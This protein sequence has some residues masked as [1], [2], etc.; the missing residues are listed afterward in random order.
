M[1]RRRALQLLGALAAVPALPALR[2]FSESELL[3]LGDRI[4]EGIEGHPYEPRTLTREQFR[5]VEI[6]AE[7]IIPR[8]HTPGATDARVA[9]FIDTMLTDWHPPAERERFIAGLNELDRRATGG[10]FSRATS[11]HR[12]ALL[13]ALDDEVTSLRRS[14]AQG[15]NE[16]WFSTL[17]FLTVWGYYTSRAGIT[18]ELRVDMMPGRYDGDAEY[19]GA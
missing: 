13:A 12:I 1:H 11:T 4:H 5:A 18:D 14:N 17:K 15:A 7:H 16:H 2:G 9:D 19:L 10:D 3:A 6:A 8:T